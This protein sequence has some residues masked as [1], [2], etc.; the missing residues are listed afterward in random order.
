M[1]N[2]LKR[3]IIEIEKL[4]GITIIFRNSILGILSIKKKI[5]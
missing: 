3:L 2:L 4:K 5:L 1:I